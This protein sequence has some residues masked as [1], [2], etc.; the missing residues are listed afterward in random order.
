MK[1]KKYVLL[2]LFLLISVLW[3]SC[4]LDSENADKQTDES[5]KDEKDLLYKPEIAEEGY[6]ISEPINSR[7][8]EN[9]KIIDMSEKE[10]VIHNDVKV[11]EIVKQ[12]SQIT[13]S[14][15]FEP[16]EEEKGAL[17]A[18]IIT[19]DGVESSYIIGS[20]TRM[21]VGDMY[22]DVIIDNDFIELLDSY[23]D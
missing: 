13:Y 11:Q 3:F 20:K 21:I 4:S 22:Y 1:A 17:Y 9:L 5:S 12:M 16:N 19:V 15:K 6:V 18:I 2:I 14:R 10:I 7:E 8:I 23:F